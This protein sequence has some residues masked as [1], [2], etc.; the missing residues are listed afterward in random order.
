MEAFVGCFS[1]LADPREDNTRHDLHEI[2]LIALCALL[3]GGED[4]SDMALF[5]RSKEGFLRQFLRLK[6]GVPSHDTFSR[7]FRHLDP[8]KFH[9]CFLKFINSFTAGLSGVVAVDGKTLRRSFDRASA[10]SPLHLVSAW[11]CEERLFLGQIAVDG[12]SNEITALPK[13]LELLALKGRVITADAMHCQRATCAA[14]VAQGGDYVIALKGNQGALHDDVRRLFTDKDHRP[15]DVA[16]ATDADHGRIE[17]RSAAVTSQIGWLTQTHA[18]PGLKAIGAITRR[19]EVALKTTEE[20]VYYL[21]SAPMDAAR[22]NATV[23][24][25]WSTRNALHWVLDVTM[26]EDASRN[27]KDHGPQNLALLRRMALNFARL[28]G[29]KGSTKA[30]LKRAGWDDAFLITILKAGCAHMR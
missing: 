29:S 18:W 9:E 21:I 17:T 10:K 4:C 30:K 8:A 3:C 7:L 5:G 22:L 27:R 28:E 23:R 12:K 16:Q 24:A 11:A 26:N 13:L 20:T 15:E 2:L 25:H 1:E 19:R 6:H 14:I